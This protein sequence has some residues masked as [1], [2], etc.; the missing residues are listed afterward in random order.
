VTHAGFE[1]LTHAD[2][3]QDC[4]AAWERGDHR[5]IGVYGFAPYTP[6]VPK[7]AADLVKA[8]GLRY[9]GGTSDAIESKEHGQAVEKAT[10]YARRYNAALLEKLQNAK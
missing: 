10:D 9:L 3:V 4:A 7:T 1:W 8:N 5:F 6:G 2:P